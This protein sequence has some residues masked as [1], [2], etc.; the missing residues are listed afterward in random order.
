MAKIFQPTLVIGVGGTGKGIILALKKMI[1]E[2][3]PRGMGDYPLLKFLSVDTDTSFP[4]VKTSIQ[5]IKASELT[6]NKS[7]ETFSLHA[8]FN[9]IPDL[10]SFPDIGAW[11]PE[12]LKHNLTPAELE[13]GAGQRKPI[14]RFSFAWNADTLK[15]RIEQLLRN[16]VDVDTAKQ[17]GI[18][19]SNL[20]KF[21]NVFICGSICGGTG[22]GTFLDMAY[23]V[24]HVA[25]HI[26]NRSIY[27]Y[28][29]LALSSIF[30]GI[31]GDENVKPNCYAS[32]VE[33]DHFMNPFTYQNP[34][35]RFFPAYKN[36]G[37]R[38]WDYSKSSE[39]GP[40]D[41]PFLFDKTNSAGFSLNSA[42]AFSEMVARFIYLLT[43]HEVANEWQSMD[44]NVR[45]NL[46]TRYIKEKYQ[47]PNNYRSMGTFSV[48][49]PRRMA[50]QM[51]AYKLA[52]VYFEKILDDSYNPQE[53][54][55]L[56][57]RFMN[58]S[59]FN[60]N[61]DL[62]KNLFDKYAAQDSNS[63]SFASF[64][65]NRKEEF[66]SESAE[67]DKKELVQKVRDWKESMDKYVTEF[68]QQNSVT[69]RNLRQEFLSYLTK[70]ISE[71][72]DLTLRKDEANRINNEPRAV[73]GSLVRTQK[74]VKNL[75]EIYTDAAEKYRKEK[76]STSDL[77][78][79]AESEYKAKVDDL[80]STVDGFFSNKK[81]ISESLED[82]ITSCTSYLNAKRENLIAE[83]IYELF[84]GIKELG[85]VRYNGLIAELEAEN[86]ILVRSVNEFKAI[87]DEVKN[88][89]RENKNYE[90]NYLCD[91]LFDY[92]DDVEGV[93]QQLIAEKGED[94][95]FEDLSKHLKNKEEN[96]GDSYENLKDF[97][98]QQML[99]AI[100]RCT[101]EYFKEPVSKI[102]ISDKLLKND[103]KLNL[104]LNGNYYNNASIYL[105][106]DGGQLSEVGLNLESSRFFAITIPDVY[107]TCPCRG[108]VGKD[109]VQ[110]RCPVD[111]DE[112]KYRGDN[113]CP[114]YPNC[115]KKRVLDNAPNNLAI[116]PTSETAEINIVTTIAGY[117][118]HAVSS[119]IHDCKPIYEQLKNKYKEENKA[120]GKQEEKLHMFGPVEFDDLTVK[121][122]DPL[123]LMKPFKKTVMFALALG[124]L[125][126]RP[127][128]VDFVTQRDLD[129]NRRDNP[130]LHLGESIEDLY[131]RFQSTRAEDQ[132][133]VKQVS[134]EM[135][136]VKDF[137]TSNEEGK[138]K[139][140]EKLKSSFEELN[141]QPPAG[142]LAEDIDLIDEISRE[143]CGL[144][145]V[146]KSEKNQIFW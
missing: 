6:L 86:Q 109:S 140:G 133:A 26:S 128:S 77:I 52:D 10:K 122:E 55:N 94:Y 15:P 99:I 58:N 69:A 33:M 68:K 35:R 72:V 76:D 88:Y 125:I 22:A 91:V 132:R 11:Y 44:N 130:S 146:K 110:K 62:L 1:A 98:H 18:G 120:S 85:L 4:E 111:E 56:V 105:G 65:D 38:Q 114:H 144:E 74:F 84:T 8:D 143:I 64:I 80:D 2:N 16:P 19:E 3:S 24:R 60:P 41:F 81:K 137:V 13:K 141:K 100:L 116:V 93:Y 21:T 42:K 145:L 67:W 104:L 27:I 46:E 103:E 126:I 63:D 9:T 43:G 25:S 50:I 49:F 107:D 87:H 136:Y 89:L 123:V 53:I 139:L 134:D 124:R 39:N 78:K 51:C 61:T 57:E 142:I 23:L 75:L 131:R 45:K 54:T 20:A 70:Q 101:E 129:A 90:S 119:A 34:Y 95:I 112:E 108:I 48:M 36:I 121:S 32:L 79:D 117:P 28:G 17:W 59:K 115:L 118:L 14:G 135:K 5:T 31:Q 30:E 12:S 29:M 92:K 138:A 47:K 7:K 96:F 106:L 40:F 102:N 127:L 97:T 113:A 66:L 83:W 37:P 73:R 82:T 71:L